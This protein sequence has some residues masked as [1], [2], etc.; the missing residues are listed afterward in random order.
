MCH[1]YVKFVLTGE[2]V[3][4]DAACQRPGFV[5]AT[6]LNLEGRCLHGCIS[7]MNRHG[8]VPIQWVPGPI[9]DFT[10]PLKQILV[11][12]KCLDLSIKIDWLGVSLQPYRHEFQ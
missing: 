7:Y 5:F 8:Q 10:S 1:G 3:L 6:G 11:G 12:Q 2:Q 4:D 9:P